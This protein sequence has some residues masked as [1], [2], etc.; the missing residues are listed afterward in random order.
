MNI[1][2]NSAVK[3]YGIK[4]L[5]SEIETNDLILSWIKE[6]FPQAT[7]DNQYSWCSIFMKI[8]AREVGVE[9]T[10]SP[11]ARAWLKIGT[12]V[13]LDNVEIGNVVVLWRKKKN[14]PWGHVGLY[15]DHDDKYVYL[16]GG[17]Q[18]NS[19]K[20]SKYDINRIL[21]IRRLKPI[22]NEE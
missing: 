5:P 21:G 22:D 12:E 2:I 15:V 13:S 18:A 6:V 17:N 14:S 7:D 10:E 16:L 4:E 9:Y 11:M 20:I 1:I 8:I 19:V 3:Y